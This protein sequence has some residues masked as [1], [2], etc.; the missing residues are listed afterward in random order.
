[1]T[2]PV[3]QISF[4][5]E[6]TFA[7]TLFVTRILKPLQHGAPKPEPI[8]QC[9]TQNDHND[10]IFT[11]SNVVS[12]CRSLSYSDVV[13]ETVAHGYRSPRSGWCGGHRERM[14]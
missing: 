5:F 14:P 10:V 6:A 12:F 13:A 7:F 2:L 11:R 9:P 3:E 8:Y 4:V 1:M